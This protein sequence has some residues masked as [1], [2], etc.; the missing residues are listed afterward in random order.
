MRRKSDLLR[1]GQHEPELEQSYAIWSDDQ[2]MDRLMKCLDRIANTERGFMSL[3]DKWITI[4]STI[5]FLLAA[6][7]PWKILN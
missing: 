3:S 2:S 7:F 1:E 6:Y 4:I 5:P